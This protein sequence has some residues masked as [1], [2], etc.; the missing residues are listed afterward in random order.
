MCA[1]LRILESPNLESAGYSEERRSAL[2]RRWQGGGRG[3]LVLVGS[4]DQDEACA[5]V[6]RREVLRGVG[7]R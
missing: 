6:S 3:A 7:V 5:E 4:I 2:D 1:E